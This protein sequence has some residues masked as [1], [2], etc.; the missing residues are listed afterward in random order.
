M[1]H[2]GP[3]KPSRPAELTQ[4]MPLSLFARSRKRGGRCLR[5][6]ETRSRGHRHGVAGLD[7]PGDPGQKLAVLCSVH[8][9]ESVVDW[10]IAP[11]IL[12][13]IPVRAKPP[14]FLAP[15]LCPESLDDWPRVLDRVQ[16]MQTA[17]GATGNQCDE[18]ATPESL[19]PHD[20]ITTEAVTMYLHAVD[21]DR[22]QPRP[23]A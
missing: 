15:G 8:R 7:P 18:D 3:S 6:R 21:V 23:I 1:G 12:L 17:A 9:L 19:L 11:T 2:A 4:G 20:G 10:S 22:S 14:P 5:P 13:D 16:T